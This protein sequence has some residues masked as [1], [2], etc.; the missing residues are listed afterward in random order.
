M[1]TLVAAEE[2]ACPPTNTRFR[3]KNMLAGAECGSRSGTNPVCLQLQRR[4]S[5]TVRRQLPRTNIPPS[6]CCGFP[7][8]AQGR[9]RV[10]ANQVPYPR[11]EESGGSSEPGSLLLRPISSQRQKQRHLAPPPLAW[12]WSWAPLS[13]IVASLLVPCQPHEATS[14]LASAASIMPAACRRPRRA[15]RLFFSSHAR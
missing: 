5:G 6:H 9:A 3:T 11:G 14:H 4:V 8:Q 7:F 1:R 12:H 2:I 10:F 13:P 15:T